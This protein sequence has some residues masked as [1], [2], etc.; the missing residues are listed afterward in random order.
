MNRAS[1]IRNLGTTFFVHLITCLHTRPCTSNCCSCTYVHC[2]SRHAPTK[3]TNNL[4]YKVI[5]HLISSTCFWPGTV[6]VYWGCSS[7]I[8]LP[9]IFS[10]HQLWKEVEVPTQWASVFW[11]L[12]VTL[13]QKK[14]NQFWGWAF[15][16]SQPCLWHESL[17]STSEQYLHKAEEK[18]PILGFSSKARFQF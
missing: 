15:N 17:Y 4:E 13:S 7:L 8:L 14:I 6:E 12:Y 11:W 3:K 5:F 18:F 9:L 16:V 2:L 10:L 1:R